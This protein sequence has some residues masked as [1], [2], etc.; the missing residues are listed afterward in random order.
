MSRMRRSSGPAA[1]I[2]LGPPASQAP[3]R[4]G[5]A[6]LR[7]GRERDRRVQQRAG[8]AERYTGEADGEQDVERELVERCGEP[9]LELVRQ[10]DA[11]PLR[12]EHAVGLEAAAVRRVEAD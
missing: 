6:R 5:H 2:A 12:H 9:R 10:E 4:V 3:R 8:D 7:L 11:V 1:K